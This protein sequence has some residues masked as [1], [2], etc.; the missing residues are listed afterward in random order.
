MQNR[1]IRIHTPRGKQRGLTLIETVIALLIGAV[2]IA[3]AVIGYQVVYGAKGQNDAQLLSQAAQCARSTYNNSP[4]FSGVSVS[5]LAGNG[6][7]P[8]SNVSG[9]IGAQTVKDTNGY[10]INAQAT[11]LNSANDSIAFT[12]SG[13]PTNVCTQIMAALA[14]SASQLTGGPV[15]SGSATTVMP[16]GGTYNPGA[17]PTA[18]GASLND[19]IYT[20]TK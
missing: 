19:V 8:P 5:T 6:C 2:I 9:A 18:C 11:T 3:G 17:V 14:P 13:V 1:S 10:S 20:I 16:Y 4:D 15:G 7:F 12:I